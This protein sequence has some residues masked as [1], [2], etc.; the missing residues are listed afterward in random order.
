VTRALVLPSPFLPGSVHAPLADALQRRGWGVAVAPLT[1]SPVGPEPVLAAFRTAVDEVAPD[2]V[3]THSNAGRYAPLVAGGVPVVHI[4]AAL[5]P[6]SGEPATL[7]PE[8]MLSVLAGMADAN[9]LLPPWTRWW[10]EEAVAEVL[11]DPVALAALRAEEW[12]MP[13]TYVRSRLGA[14]V[15]WAERPQAYLAFG[16]TYAVEVALARGQGWPVERVQ[17]AGHL[18]HLV[19]PGLVA[20]AVVELAAAL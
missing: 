11:P 6:A 9:G 12:P 14:P 5:P 19:E 13:L 18:H 17:G 4:D 10:S 15:G 1:A 20:D 3:L 7:A 8:A 16:D 2:V